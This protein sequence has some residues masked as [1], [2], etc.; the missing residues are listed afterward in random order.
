MKRLFSLIAA[1]L[2]ALALA[3]PAFAAD[4]DEWK[5]TSS[6]ETGD[7]PIL[8]IGASRAD[9]LVDDAGL[10]SAAEQE[11]VLAVL[12]RESALAGC[13]FAVLTEYGVDEDEIRSY[14]EN[15]YLT[16]GYAEDGV[17]LVISRSDRNAQIV[18]H[19]ACHDVISDGAGVDYLFDQFISYLKEDEW[20]DAFE[21][22][23]MAARGMMQENAETGRVWKD[24]YNPI[25]ILIGAVAGLIAAAVAT[26]AMK[27]KMKSV[28]FQTSAANYVLPGTLELTASQD[29]FLYANVTR[30]ARPKD[31]G[32][33]S[34]SSGGGGGGSFGG[35]SRHF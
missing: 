18:T 23:A 7:G 14:A 15:W 25:W 3:L 32:S 2:I 28:R 22:F 16:Q 8:T 12:I 9:L 19:G 6:Y 11:S 20:A 35:G 10:L 31:T 1:L 4:D 21:H 27:S 5:D 33:S 34:R 13:D 30:V 29:L 26:G 24:P 17:L